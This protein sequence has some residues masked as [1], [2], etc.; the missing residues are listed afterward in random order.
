M[1]IVASHTMYVFSDIHG[2]FKALCYQMTEVLKVATYTPATLEDKHGVWT[3]DKNVTETVVLCLGDFVDRYRTPESKTFSTEKAIADEINIIKCFESLGSQAKNFNSDVI[4]L[5]GNHELANIM[6]LE[7]YRPFQM[8]DSSNPDDRRQ[9]REFVDKYLIPFASKAGVI[10]QWSNYFVCHGGLEYGWLKRHNIRSVEEINKR[11]RRYITH[12]L[13]KYMEIFAEGDGLL[14]SRK[15]S[16]TPELWRE[17]DKTP[18]SDLFGYELLPKFV[19]GHTTVQDLLDRSVNVSPPKCKNSENS[20]ILS[21]RGY[22]GEDDIF[23]VD[24]QLSEAFTDDNSDFQN[25]FSR[26][27]QALKFVTHIDSNMDVLFTECAT[28]VMSAKIFPMYDKRNA[29]S[30]TK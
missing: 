10:A 28:V 29:R 19:V 24:V 21:S 27:P 17:Q 12:D 4:A 1:N 25:R 3:W 13:K 9:R 6:D 7:R 26:R 2:D 14:W 5:I 11:W 16:H 15:I 23:Y 18:I 8:S 20:L 22:D 30:E